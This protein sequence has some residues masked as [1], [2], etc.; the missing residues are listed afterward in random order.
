MRE[1]IDSVSPNRVVKSIGDVKHPGRQGYKLS[2]Y[3]A[4]IDGMTANI[5]YKLMKYLRTPE[6]YEL[7]SSKNVPMLA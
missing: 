1:P 5:S 3:A 6:K 7:Q 4:K 2:S